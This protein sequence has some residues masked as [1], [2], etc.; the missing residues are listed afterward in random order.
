MAIAYVMNFCLPAQCTGLID[1]GSS[2]Q[3]LFSHK[4]ST[5]WQFLQCSKQ[6]QAC[7]LVEYIPPDFFLPFSFKKQG[8]ANAGFFV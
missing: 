6:K 8:K 3:V 5:L 1:L 7:Q 2:T 4:S